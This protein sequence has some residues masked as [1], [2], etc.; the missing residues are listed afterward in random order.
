MRG[1]REDHDTVVFLAPPPHA[2]TSRLR[3]FLEKSSDVLQLSFHNGIFF[4]IAWLTNDIVL[5]KFS[6]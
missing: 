3:S 5:H 6:T 4:S 2:F 1:V